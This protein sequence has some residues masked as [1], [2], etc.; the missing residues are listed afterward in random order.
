MRRKK[1]RV[2]ID[3]N[4]WISFLL[5]KK[6]SGL[7]KLFKE[8]SITILFSQELLEEFVDVVRRPKLKKYF[9]L[10]D[11]EALLYQIHQ[12][13]EF[14]Q[15]TSDVEICRDPK[16]NFLL[17]L[18]IDGEASYLLT[19]DNDLLEL[20]KVRKTKIMTLTSFLARKNASR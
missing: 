1:D 19:G 3:T 14:I 6:N 4:L 5:S 13:A 7:D 9:N 10:V 8:E 16:D 20:N 17:S 18:A 12:H 2:I 15:V 11:I